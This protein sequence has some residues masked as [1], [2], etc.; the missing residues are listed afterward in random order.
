MI[1]IAVGLALQGSKPFCYSITPFLLY[2][3]FEWIRNYLNH[4]RIPVRLAGCG[5]DED[6][7][8]DGFTHHASDA[9]SVLN[10]FPAIRKHFPVD[11]EDVPGIV[12]IMLETNEPSFICLRRP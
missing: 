2:R 11:K 4:E 10:L 5:L 12:S 9:V 1:G 7:S 6:Y 3:P 8:V